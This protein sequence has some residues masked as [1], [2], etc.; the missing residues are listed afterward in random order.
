M[1]DYERFYDGE[2]RLRRLRRDPPFA[3]QF[4]MTVTGLEEERVRRACGELRNSLIRVAK[5]YDMEVL[6]PAPAP[7]L[8]VNHR[9]RYRLTL[10]G[11]NDKATRELLSAYMKEFARRGENRGMNIYTDC[12]LMD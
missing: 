7:V 9:Y 10:I 11:H 1:Q 5:E 4:M 2:I 6:G 8:K 12:N 3:D